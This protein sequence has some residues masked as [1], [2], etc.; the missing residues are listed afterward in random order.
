M[1]I[2]TDIATR[3][4]AM[5]AVLF[6]L[7]SGP[8]AFLGRRFDTAARLALAPVLGL[9]AGTCVFTTLIWL[10]AADN[11]YWLVPVLACV[12]VGFALR[13]TFAGAAGRGERGGVARMLAPVRRLGAFDA[14]A[15]LAV[16]VIVAAPLDYTLHERHS[17][18]PMGFEVWDSVDYTA[19]P[20]GMEQESIR[21]ASRPLSASEVRGFV[22]GSGGRR[23]AASQLRRSNFIRLFWTFY[24]SGDQNLDAAPLSANVNA[25]LGLHGTETQGLF[26]IA[27]L[28]VGA[29]GAFGAIRYAVPRQRWAAPF[30]GVLFAG[31]FY[32]QLVVDGSQAAICGLAVILPIVAVGV[33]ALRER[34][35][36]SLVLLAILGSGLLALYPL[37]APMVV[38]ASLAVL[39]VLGG[40]ARRRGQLRRDLL[41]RVLLG[42]GLVVALSA[43]LDLVAFTR[44]LRYWRDV[45][46]GD[47][48]AAGLPQYHLPLSVLPGW[49]LQTREFYS[50]TE[51]GSAGAHEL[52]IGAL[53][54]L[55]LIAVALFGLAR[56]R[57][58]L[59]LAPFLLACAALAAYVSLAQNCSYCTDRNLLPAAPLG[60]GLVA[61]GVAALLAARS[62]WLR[63]AG[64]LVALLA[65]LAVAA[66]TRQERLRF[67]DGAY[68]LDAGDRALLAQLPSRPG[69]VDLEGYG[70]DL[71]K[72]PGELPLVYYMVSE[73]THGHV[74]LPSEFVDYS[75]LAYLGEA[76]PRNP[77]F[78]PDYR[79]VLT[80]IGGVQTARRVV[81]RTGSLALEERAEPVDVTVVS[82]LGVPPVRLDM[83]G[84]PWVEGPLHLLAVGDAPGPIWI[85]MRFATLVPVSAPPQ[86][87]VS[88]R[89]R[90]ATVTACVR[91]RGGAPVRKATLTMSFPQVA[92]IVP[93]EPFAIPEEPQAMQLVAMRAV[94]RCSL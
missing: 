71:G 53:I 10:T 11:T 85:S 52:L 70:E 57:A 34:A 65:L 74:S 2:W 45:L 18:G 69:Y 81:A 60:I 3:E 16:C 93:A 4:L 8:A 31:P 78:N 37:F 17:T 55:A 7:G 51:L 79:Y 82:G 83:S 43:V 72:A 80:R 94:R 40:L 15:L 62:R 50:L 89:T 36:S 77:Q 41:L 64:V 35:P 59:V 76:N 58:A 9:C 73:E 33:D 68:F 14:L 42:V 28:I 19:E 49:L 91:A 27:F 84:L 21:Q 20:D 29:L 44:D 5:L 54:P 26:L 48:F 63:L 67:A 38:L 13:R 25:F 32:M 30:A 1:H 46:R 12:S 92:G 47:Y 66:R 90:G 56:Q 88:I 75:S 6:A 87:G 39:V 24:A 86:P 23:P 22:N 61:L